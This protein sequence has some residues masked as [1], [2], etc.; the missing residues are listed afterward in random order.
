MTGARKHIGMCASL[1]E[2]RRLRRS[3][4]GGHSSPRQLSGKSPIC[5]R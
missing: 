2:Q 4:R 1:A 5:W 3:Y